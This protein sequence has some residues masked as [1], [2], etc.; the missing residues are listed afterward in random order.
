MTVRYL[1]TGLVQGV[2]FRWY[3]LRGAQA[4]GLTGFVRNLADGRVEV[5]G[6]GEPAGLAR[7]E[8]LLRQGPRSARVARVD[9]AEILDEVETYKMFAVK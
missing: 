6:Q 5:V 7:L 2:G 4:L 9:K 8:E 1:V 3:T